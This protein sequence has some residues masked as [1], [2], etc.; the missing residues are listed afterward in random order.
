MAKARAKSTFSV[1]VRHGTL[2]HMDDVNTYS[3]PGQ[4]TKW[5]LGRVAIH[6]EWAKRYNKNCAQQLDKIRVNISE[7]DPRGMHVGEVRTWEA[8]DDHTQVTFR[9]E[10]ELVSR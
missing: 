6:H 8:T 2:H 10:M 7:T 9:F 5:L 3:Q 4:A 1:K